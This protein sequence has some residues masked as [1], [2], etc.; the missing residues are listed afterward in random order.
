M[1]RIIC[2]IGL[3]LI[4][5]LRTLAS[6][7]AGVEKVNIYV[8]HFLLQSWP[9]DKR[10]ITMQIDTMFPPDTLVFQA[11]S[12]SGGLKRS[13]LQLWDMAGNLIEEV[14]RLTRLEDESEATFIY[15]LN[16]ENVKKMKDRRFQVI[17]DVHQ[18]NDPEPHNVALIFLDTRH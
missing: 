1:V 11:I 9:K 12:G 8:G 7:P 13:T 15:V 4:F 2:C 17:L 10:P 18:D 14:A 6:P 3:L 16:R 5:V